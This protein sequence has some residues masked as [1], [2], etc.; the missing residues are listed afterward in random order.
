MITPGAKDL[1]EDAIRLAAATAA[2]A[3]QVLAGLMQL[4]NLR[5]GPD[6]NADTDLPG[7]AVGAELTHPAGG[8]P[9]AEHRGWR[10]KL[11]GARSCPAS[12]AGA[13]ARGRRLSLTVLSTTLLDVDCFIRDVAQALARKYP[14]RR[15]W[16]WWS[17]LDYDRDGETW[18][19][20]RMFP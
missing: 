6:R 20:C 12:A 17:R 16:Q 9:T 1:T 8:D 5:A 4:Q 7:C 19:R 2:A 15:W 11:V 14:P 13:M 18:V 3:A 10:E